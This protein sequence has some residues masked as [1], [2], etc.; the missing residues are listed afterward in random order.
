MSFFNT[1]TTTREEQTSPKTENI[2]ANDYDD[3]YISDIINTKKTTTSSDAI[4]TEITRST[5]AAAAAAAA[6]KEV[7]NVINIDPDLTELVFPLDVGLYI[8]PTPLNPQKPPPIPSPPEKQNSNKPN[9]N[10]NNKYKEIINNINVLRDEISYFITLNLATRANNFVQQ[11]NVQHRYCNDDNTVYDLKNVVS[12]QNSDIKKL[13][14]QIIPGKYLITDINAIYKVALD[15]YIIKNNRAQR[16]LDNIDD[17]NTARQKI[18]DKYLPSVTSLTA[19]NDSLKSSIKIAT[20]QLNNYNNNIL[21][22]AAITLNAVSTAA[23]ISVDGLNTETQRYI[24]NLHNYYES[25]LVNNTLFINQMQDMDNAAVNNNR[26]TEF[27]NASTFSFI[28]IKKYCFIIYYLLLFVLFV[29][30]A[31]SYY[32]KTRVEFIIYLSIVFILVIFPFI[33]LYLEIAIYNF[34]KYCISIISGTT[35]V[36]FNYSRYGPTSIDNSRMNNIVTETTTTNNPFNSTYLRK[37]IS[38]D[39]EKTKGYLYNFPSNIGNFIYSL[40]TVSKK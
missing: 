9:N 14:T 25:I 28:S 16:I 8:P 33:I 6:V 17:E 23:K 15:E 24:E 3:N 22:S 37:P 30:F 34:Y 31:M 5:P 13:N 26:K 18:K 40:Y 1:H 20:D 12:A 39:Y 32:T 19:Q 29:L 4:N 38:F 7:S 27:K 10:N 36:P 2:V 11:A 21:P 35:F